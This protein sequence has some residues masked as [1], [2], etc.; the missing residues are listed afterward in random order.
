MI[1]KLY[2]L[3]NQDIS[4]RQFVEFPDWVNSLSEHLI[5]TGHCRSIHSQLICFQGNSSNAD[6]E[7][8]LEDPRVWPLYTREI[9]Y[10]GIVN[11][12]E[13]DRILQLEACKIGFNKDSSYMC[14]GY[15][16][17]QDTG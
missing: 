9:V 4:K 14:D 6:L 12:Q 11:L 7:S 3:S 17:R 1:Y 10:S 5:V 13:I 8:L 2:Y 15:T 16:V